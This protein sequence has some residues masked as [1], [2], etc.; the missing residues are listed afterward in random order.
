MAATRPTS[1]LSSKLLNYNERGNQ[2]DEA[3]FERTKR[4]GRSKMGAAVL[5]TLPKLTRKAYK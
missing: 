4:L 5:G 1:T 2:F 3:K